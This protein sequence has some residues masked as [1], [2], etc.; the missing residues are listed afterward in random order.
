MSMRN[1]ES[2]D[3]TLPPG[4]ASDFASKIFNLRISWV[5]ESE[6]CRSLNNHQYYS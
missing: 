5:Q 4:L 6:Y 1:H 2:E 3:P